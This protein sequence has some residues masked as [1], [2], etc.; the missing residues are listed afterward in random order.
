MKRLRVDR[1]TGHLLVARPRSCCSPASPAAVALRSARPDHC[2]RS[3]RAQSTAA[4][5]QQVS[6][7]DYLSESKSAFDPT[8]LPSPLPNRALQSAKLAA[9]HARLSLSPKIPLQALARTLVDASADEHPQFNNTNLAF[10]GQT[11]INYHVAEWLMCRYPRLPMPI[12]WE[13]VKAYCGPAALFQV[14]RS[15]GVEHAAAPGGEVDPGLLQFSVH[16]PKPA[17]TLVGLGYKRVE[18]EPDK[19]HWRRGISNRVVFDDDFGNAVDITPNT[20]TRLDLMQEDTSDQQTEPVYTSYGTHRTREIAEEA[21]ATFV[22]AVVGAIYAHCG[23]ESAKAF[24]KAHILS[25][26]LDLARL[27]R[28]AKPTVELATLCAREDFDAPV[29]RLL[30][31]TGRLSRTPVFVVGIYSGKDKL[32]EAA[33]PSLDAA[34]LKA[35]INALKAWYLYSPGDKVRVPSD[36]LVEGA[37]KWE[38]AHIDLGE[39]VTSH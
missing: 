27:F 10:V 23:R 32:G 20:E 19:R 8:E 28:F 24:V 26:T 21:H 18:A 11:I 3:I 13:A 6:E 2:I 9:L 29:A 15:W 35:A 16:N 4:A 38:P 22:R 1:L 30:S 17:V 7:V 31:E 37:A 33:G 5:A 39:I 14:A 12:I 25:R 34:R 36:M